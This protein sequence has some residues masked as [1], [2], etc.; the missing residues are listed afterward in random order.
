MRTYN[1]VSH[2]PQL[3]PIASSS[4]SSSSAMDYP[5]PPP[6]PHGPEEGSSSNSGVKR[7]RLGCLTCRKRRVGCP[8]AQRQTPVLTLSQVKCDETKPTCNACRRLQKECTWQDAHAPSTRRLPR[9][10]NATACE[11]CRSRKVSHP[12]GLADESSNARATRATAPA[13]AARAPG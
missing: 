1:F 12:I 3:Q 6:P 2:H 7:T 10:P 11:A 5:P 9:R 8:T 4:S 13:R